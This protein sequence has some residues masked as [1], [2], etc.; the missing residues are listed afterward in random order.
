MGGAVCRA[1]VKEEKKKSRSV[2]REESLTSA[3]RIRRFTVRNLGF[4]VLSL[5]RRGL[6]DVPGELM[7][8][9]ELQKLNL[10]LNSLKLLPPQIALLCNLEVLNLWGNQVLHQ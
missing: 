4:N 1:E 2:G 6:K 7:E 10:S 3:D 8:L 5:A 9:T